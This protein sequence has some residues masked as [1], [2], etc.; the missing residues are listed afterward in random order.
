[1][2]TNFATAV[3]LW[4]SCVFLLCL[5]IQVNAVDLDRCRTG[6]A[7]GTNQSGPPEITYN[8]C[9]ET[10]GKGPGDFQWT[11]FSQGFGSW[12]LPWIALIFQLPF[13][14]TGA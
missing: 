9:L 4:L 11:M 12:L 3:R 1:M 14:A 6:F 7:N 13:G 5:F 2:L 10:C 8:Q